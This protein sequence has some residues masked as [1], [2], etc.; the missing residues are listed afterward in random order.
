M[1]PNALAS[2][3]A[4]ADLWSH[5]KSMDHALERCLDPQVVSIEPL[6]KE[7]ISALVSFLRENFIR[8]PREI[9]TTSDK[10]FSP[11]FTLIFALDFDLKQRLQDLPALKDWHRGSKMGTEKKI[12]KLINTIEDF[13]SN[14]PKEMFKKNVP[15]EEFNILRKI[16]HALLSD[17]QSALYL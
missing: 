10:S 2:T 14:I 1:I 12:E 13:K 4:Y 17:M 11:Y 7:R 15:Q 3:G 8:I 16:L 9:F 6:D 5:L